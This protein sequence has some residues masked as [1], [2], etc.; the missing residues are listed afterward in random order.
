[1]S[2]NESPVTVASAKKNGPCTFSR[3]TA[4]KNRWLLES[5]AGGLSVHVI[6]RFPRYGHCVHLA[7]DVKM[8]L[9][10]SFYKTIFLHFQLHLLAKVMPF[11]FVC[12]IKG[13]HQLHLVGLK[14]NCLCNS[15]H[16]IT[17]GMHNSL[18]PLPTDLRGLRWNASRTLSM[19]S[20]DTWVRPGLLPTLAFTQASSFYK[21]VVPPA[22]VVCLF[23][24]VHETHAAL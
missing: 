7:T 19:L 4:Y 5:H 11:H 16:T 17:F 2:K 15:F 12:W 14:D 9:H 3:D 8:W 6:T 20:S 18:L 10:R 23:E 1:M 13:L 22:C 21:L 24:T